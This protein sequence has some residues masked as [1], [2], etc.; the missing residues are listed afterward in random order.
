MSVPLLRRTSSSHSTDCGKIDPF[1]IEIPAKARQEP[2]VFVRTEQ[3]VCTLQRMFRAKYMYP[4]RMHRK[5]LVDRLLFETSIVRGTFRLVNQALIFWL[6]V[7]AAMMG[8]DVAVKRGIYTDLIDAYSLDSLLDIKSR[9]DFVK[10]L[11]SISSK[12][13]EFFIFS[14]KYFDTADSGGNEYRLYVF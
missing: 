10:A 14:S 1:S 9:A 6:M 12:S 13:K 8:S 3:A 5:H 2:P 4:A 7:V 11:P